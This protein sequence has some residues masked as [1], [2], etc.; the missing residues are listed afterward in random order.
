[1]ISGKQLK[2]VLDYSF[3]AGTTF[4]APTATFSAAPSS[5][6]I[7]SV[8]GTVTLT[9][10]VT[11]NDGTSV[12]WTI[13]SGVTLLASG[14]GNS[15][16]HNLVSIP[17]SL[18]TS[19]YNLNITYTNVTAGTTAVLVVPTSV[20]VTASCLVG[21][22][23][24]PTQDILIPG[25]LT[26]YEG[27]LVVSTQGTIINVFGIVAANTG[28]LIITIPDSYGAVVL[29]EDGSGLD[30]LSQFN[31]TADPTNSRTIYSSVNIVTPG[32]YNY[33]IIF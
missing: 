7:A 24:S 33:K 6:T 32:T 20:V 9:G 13:T 1:M 22:M 17:S 3:S 28:R 19:V 21:Q 15:I 25:D 27:A 2:Q 26:P 11:P 12:T 18:G 14:S 30:V 23:N 10:S 5:Y 4:L 8:P 29:I 16:S 31:T